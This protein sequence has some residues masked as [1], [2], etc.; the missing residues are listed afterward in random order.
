MLPYIGLCELSVWWT[1]VIS[2]FTF[3]EGFLLTVLF[4]RISGV[5]VN[6]FISCP[7]FIY[8]LIN[9]SVKAECSLNKMHRWTSSAGFIFHEN[10]WTRALSWGLNY[11]YHGLSVH[12]MAAVSYK[13]V[14][15]MTAGFICIF[16]WV[17]F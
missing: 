8:F 1:C 9:R 17:K 7:H 14:L 16:T 12:Y 3:Y 11:Q 13:E 15:Q 2:T 6:Q 5:S 10:L 4:R